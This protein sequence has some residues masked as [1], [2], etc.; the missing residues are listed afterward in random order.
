MLVLFVLES[1]ERGRGRLV[2]WFM[3]SMVERSAVYKA[4][5]EQK[6]GDCKVTDELI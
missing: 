5:R 3:P 4:A 2:A 6:N 1:K